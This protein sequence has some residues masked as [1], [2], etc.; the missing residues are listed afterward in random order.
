MDGVAILLLAAGSSSRMR[1]HDKLLEDVSGEPLLR[2]QARAALGTGAR[3]LV[4]LRC[5]DPERREALEG[6]AAIS[7]VEVADADQGMGVSIAAGALA[8]PS[9]TRWLAVLPA[10]MPELTCEDIAA[11]LVFAAG[12][13]HSVVRGAGPKGAPGH[14]VVF[15]AR[16]F[17]ALAQLSGD[18]G[19][20][21]VLRG[22]QVRLCPLPGRHALTDLDTPEDWAAWRARAQ[23]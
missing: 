10:D 4:T 19:A 20:R 21:S 8:V 5:D 2:R 1:G 16:L 11:V 18:Q 23:Y 3:V 15:P 22:E 7:V 14:P 17:G 13:P 12:H 9:G 6:L